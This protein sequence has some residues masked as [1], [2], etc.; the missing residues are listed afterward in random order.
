MLTQPRAHLLADPCRLVQVLAERPESER[1]GQ[2]C[3]TKR[4]IVLIGQKLDK[5]D[6][7]NTW[8]KIGQVFL[9]LPKL[10]CGQ[11]L[12]KYWTCNCPKFVNYERSLDKFENLV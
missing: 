11:I 6:M 9:D 5:L 3:H 4:Q 1:H 2:M 12:D 7:D 8:T 10:S